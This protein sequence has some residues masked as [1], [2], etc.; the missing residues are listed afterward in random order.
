MSSETGEEVIEKYERRPF[1]LLHED[2]EKEIRLT[3]KESEEGKEDQM[4]KLFTGMAKVSKSIE[5]LMKR[6]EKI[7]AWIFDKKSKDQKSKQSKKTKIKK[8]KRSLWL[9]SSSESD[10][11][12]SSS[13]SSNSSSEENEDEEEELTNAFSSIMGDKFQFV[14]PNRGSGRKSKKQQ[15]GPRKSIL[16]S[17]AKHADELSL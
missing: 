9:P 11:E 15:P 16:F 3:H 14:N 17:N 7:E 2:S 10:S 12:D 1:V 13:S 6:Q 4:A 8:N 5:K